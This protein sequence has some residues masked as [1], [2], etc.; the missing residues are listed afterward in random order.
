MPKPHTAKFIWKNNPKHAD[1][2]V[3][4]DGNKLI[5]KEIHPDLYEWELNG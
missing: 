1:D 3:D 5:D 4:E 2:T